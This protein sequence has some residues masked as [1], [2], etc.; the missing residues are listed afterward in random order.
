MSRTMAEDELIDFYATVS[1][2]AS[3]A[4]KRGDLKAEKRHRWVMLKIERFDDQH[5]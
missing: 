4:Q 1:W 3:M 2:E 5:T